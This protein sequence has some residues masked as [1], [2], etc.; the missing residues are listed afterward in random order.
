MD[1]PFYPWMDVAPD[2]RVFYSGPDNNLR[3][4]DPSGAGAWQS[5][6]GRD[7]ENRDYGSHALYDIG[8]ILV[9]GGGPSSRTA[10]TIDMN[11]TTPQV[12]TTSPMAFGRR[13]FNL[14]TLADGT[15]LATGG[16]STG[17]HYIDMN[18]G[19]YKAELWNPA[20][21]Q[22][23]DARRRVRSRAS[24]TRPRCCC[25]T[26]ACCRPGAASA[27]T[28]TRSATWARTRRSSLRRTCSRRTAP[29]SSRR[30]PRSVRRR[31]RCP[32]APR[33]RSRPPMRPRSA[34]SRWYGSAP[35][36]TRSTW[37][38]ATSHSS[39]APAAMGCPRRSPA[40]ANLTPPGF[41]ML[42]IVDAAG[43]PSVAK[44]VQVSDGRPRHLRTS[45]RPLRSHSRRMARPSPRRRP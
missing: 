31:A 11:G 40:N 8:K 20:T 3:K 5:F 12:S 32:T 26:A 30:V 7:G 16:N 14:T 34:R 23:D 19:V 35:T 25:R 43:V 37:S 9:A 24:T 38:S 17:T 36:L 28:A 27:M 10:R 21:R 18:G 39:S 29:A 45:R 41:Y 6:G 33:S 22:L 4:L 1:V 42:F 15:V 13:Q 2:G 44:M